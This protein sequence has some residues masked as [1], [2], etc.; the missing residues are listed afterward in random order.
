[1]GI[2][3][4][5]HV[6]VRTPDL[7][8]ATAYYTEVMGLQQVSARGRPGL[9]QVLGRGGPP[10]AA[11]ALRPAHR[12]GL[13]HLPRRA[14]GR[15]ARLRE[16]PRRLRLPGRAGEQGRG[17]R[18]GRVDPLRGA[19]RPDHGAGLGHRE[20]RQHPRQAQPVAGAAAGP[21]RHRA[22]AHGPHAVN[23]EEVGEAARFFQEVLGLRL[24]E[25]VLD[26]NGHQLGVWLRAAPTPRTTSRSS[27]GPTARCTT[28]PSGS[29]T[30]TTSARPPT[31][32]P[33]TACR[34]TRA[35]PGTASPAATPSTSSTRSASATR[36]SPAATAPTRTPEIITWTEDKF[37]Q[38]LFYYENVI[39]QRFLRVHT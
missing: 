26:G 16:A 11:D 30:G 5:A 15:P 9:L 1:M 19:V 2:L 33:T 39:S 8:L 23:A 7:D 28:S 35:R 25:Q 32:W 17:G 27:T 24:T 13:V 6:D 36:C 21:A 18:A 14:R 10:L 34:S 22:A 4:L 3:R 20:D 37:G 38:G 29:T 31:S 12:A